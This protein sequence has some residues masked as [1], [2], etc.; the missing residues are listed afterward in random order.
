MQLPGVGRKVADCIRLFSL[1]DTDAIPVDT[2]VLTTALGVHSTA[3]AWAMART[4]IE[5]ERVLTASAGVDE[6][7]MMDIKTESVKTRNGETAL[8]PN[9]PYVVGIAR[10]ILKKSSTSGQV[11]GSIIGARKQP[12]DED[13]DAT[14]EEIVVPQK[15]R[16]STKKDEKIAVPELLPEIY[17]GLWRALTRLYGNVWR[18]AR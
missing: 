17:H 14:E 13:S 6:S 3:I 5:R 16:K 1:G 7:S 9:L 11:G 8:Y 10:E 4:V 2:H 12:V 18:H 15:K